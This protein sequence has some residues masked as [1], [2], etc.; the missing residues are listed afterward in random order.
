M[1]D[2]QLTNQK[3]KERAKRVVM[4]ITDIEYEAAADYI[5]RADGQVKTALVMIKAKISKK[6]AQER[7]RKADGFVR[8]AIN[9][10]IEN[11]NNSGVFR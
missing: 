7:L 9:M 1:I 4:T 6:E 5:E 10:V 3:L 2:L 8:S 11:H